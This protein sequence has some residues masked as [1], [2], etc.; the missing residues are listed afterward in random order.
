MKSEQIARV[1]HEVNRAYCQALGDMSQPEWEDAPQWQKDS[2]LLGVDLHTSKNVGPEASHESWMAQK[3]AEGWKFG[4]KKDPEKK[5]HPCIVP[6]QQLAPEQQ[7]K[8]FIFRAV[9]HAL[10]STAPAEVPPGQ[11]GIKIPC[12]NAATNQTLW[13]DTPQEVA[14][15]LA[16]QE[17]PGDWTGFEA[18]GDLP[19]PGQPEKTPE[20]AS[21]TGLIGKVVDAAKK[22]VG[23]KG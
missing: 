21:K 23:S 18:F 15:H 17:H 10:R 1:C 14:N 16:K 7:A 20:P 19:E 12:R 8:D 22:M 6:F 5:E 2:A 3:L 13:F 4:P 11:A 9:V